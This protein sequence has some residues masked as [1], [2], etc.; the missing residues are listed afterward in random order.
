MIRKTRGNY[1]MKIL[2]TA[3]LAAG[4][5]SLAACGGGASNNAAS[6]NTAGNELPPVENLTDY[7]TPAPVDANASNAATS[8]AA[9]NAAATNSTGN[10]Q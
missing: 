4:L 2:S 9:G 10:A 8:N 6:S 3:L 5:A 7:N 1:A